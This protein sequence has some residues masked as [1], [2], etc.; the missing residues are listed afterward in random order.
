MKRLALGVVCITMLTPSVYA[1]GDGLPIAPSEFW[2]HWSFQWWVWIPLL[3]G[4]WLYGRGVARA[5]KRGGYGRII[6][7]SQAA[8]LASGELVLVVALISPLDPLGE[9]LLTAHMSQHILL[10]T[11]AP[12]LLVLGQPV[13]AWTWG[14]PTAWRR[15]GR[16]PLMRA[17]VSTWRWLTQ[18]LRAVVLHS[19]ALWLWHAPFLFDAALRDEG[20]HTLE[21]ISFFATA[22]MF[23]SAMMRRDTAPA[24][25]AFLI[26]VVFVQ[27][28]MLGAIVTLAPDQLYAYGDRPM[29]WGLSGVEDQQIAGLLMW[30]PAGL[31]YI[32]PFAWLASR[33]IEADQAR[34]PLRE[35]QGIMR[36]ST[37]SRSMK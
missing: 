17:L 30:A 26:L 33:V 5:W 27:C 1:H 14:L 13:I 34:G 28:G 20:V 8:A 21:H 12:L 11:L 18:P 16:A 6:G 32:I 35:S 24:F 31:L 4:H 36:A 22:L 10:T 15:L 7:P 29:L 25:A 2:H 3:I 9:T 23:W 37:S 19:A